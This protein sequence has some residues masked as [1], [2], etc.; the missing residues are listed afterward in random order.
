MPEDDKGKGKQIEVD[1]QMVELGLA[2]TEPEE[3]EEHGKGWREF[4]TAVPGTV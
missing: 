4:A 3:H 2:I 1:G